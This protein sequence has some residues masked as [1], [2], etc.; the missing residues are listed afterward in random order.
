[1]R[2]SA[3]MKTKAGKIDFPGARASNAGDA[4]EEIRAM[5]KA[6][7]PLDPESRLVC[8]TVEGIPAAS[9][10]E[11]N[12]RSRGGADCALFH[13]E[14]EE[15]P[16]KRTDLVQLKYSSSA[17][18]RRNRGT[19]QKRF[20][21]LPRRRAN[22]VTM[23]CERYAMRLKPKKSNRQKSVKTVFP[24]MLE[25]KPDPIQPAET[26]RRGAAEKYE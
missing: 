9:S 15:G 3:N 20:W 22:R 6:P 23:K 12:N 19:R 1:M 10:G 25:N 18:E 11:N 13:G 21:I 17:P 2:E 16:F 26:E 4:F 24:E 14:S 7:E 5:G 8:P